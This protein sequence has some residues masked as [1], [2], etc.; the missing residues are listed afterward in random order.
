MSVVGAG[1]CGCSC[2][3]CLS[4]GVLFGVSVLTSGGDGGGTWF[5]T[6][7]AAMFAQLV[8]AHCMMLIAYDK[9][10]VWLVWKPQRPEICELF[11]CT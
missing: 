11:I 2:M 9:A 7:H 1:K 4:F 8:R 10:P 3:C 5:A 6:R